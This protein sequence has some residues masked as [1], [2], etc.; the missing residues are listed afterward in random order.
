MKQPR[1]PGL[2]SFG[3]AKDVNKHLNFF[4]GMLNSLY[5]QEMQAEPE[6]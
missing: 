3:W 6:S 4:I 1:D 2:S 5:F